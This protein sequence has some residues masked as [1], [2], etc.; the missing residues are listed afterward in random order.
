[1]SSGATVKTIKLSDTHLVILSNAAGRED[2][3]V[4]PVPSSL[5]AKGAALTKALENLMRRG[6]IDARAAKLN[7]EHWKVAADGQRHTL[8]ITDA[9]LEAL[10]IES[11]AKPH[12][13]KVEK[14]EGEQ[15]KPPR[16]KVKARAS[17]PAPVARQSGNKRADTKS[18]TIL[19]LLRRSRGASIAELMEASNWQAH[20][21]RGY[22]SGALKKKQGLTI[23]SAKDEHG[24]RRYRVSE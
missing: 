3:S 11:L 13:S 12:R 5:K 1:M 19:R 23:V 10:G 18:A 20:S 7:E 24:T 2:F 21:V 6:L 17:K 4:L 16:P 22:L 15:R 8:A 14:Q 9:G